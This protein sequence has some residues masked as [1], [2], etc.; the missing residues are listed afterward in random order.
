MS[1]NHPPVQEPLV[2]RL[3]EKVNYG[4][5]RLRAIGKAWNDRLK[6]EPSLGSYKYYPETPYHPRIP[7]ETIESQ[8]LH[9]EE[10]DRWAENMHGEIVSPDIVVT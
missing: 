4:I 10:K 9:N 3:Q 2:Q 1:S 8:D 6:A 7:N 5:S